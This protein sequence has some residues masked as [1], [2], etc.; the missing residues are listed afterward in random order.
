V[1]FP[2]DGGAIGS[3]EGFGSMGAPD[4]ANEETINRI[5]T[6]SS[7]WTV[8]RDGYVRLSVGELPSTSGSTFFKINGEIAFGHYGYY[9]SAPIGNIITTVVPVR[10]GQVISVSNDDTQ[11]QPSSYSLG[12][13][14]IPSIHDKASIAVNTY[15]TY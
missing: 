13:Y 8:D 15:M 11:T 3:I 5:N 6:V 10:K 9:S 14:Y 1:I 7:T 4:Y 2:Y 12:C